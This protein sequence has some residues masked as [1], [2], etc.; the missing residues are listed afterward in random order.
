M[1]RKL[2][3]SNLD[4]PLGYHI[5]QYFREDNLEVNPSLKIIGSS[6]SPEA[7]RGVHTKIDVLSARLSSANTPK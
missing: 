3:I 7:L 2:Y 6:C 5:A 1:Q 4:S